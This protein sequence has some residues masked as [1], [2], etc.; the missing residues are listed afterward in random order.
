MSQVFNILETSKNLTVFTEAKQ[1]DHVIQ[2]H[3]IL[4]EIPKL[5]SLLEA[6][7]EEP[8]VSTHWLRFDAHLVLFFDSVGDFTNRKDS[9]KLVE[10]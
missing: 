6:R 8:T 9:E 7:S 4:D 10:T 5:I 2:K 1:T 3:I